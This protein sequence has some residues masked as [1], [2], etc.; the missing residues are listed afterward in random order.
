MSDDDE[1]V[2]AP[3]D[4]LLPPD[5][6]DADAPDG[7]DADPLD[8]ATAADDGEPRQGQGQ[9]QGQGREGEL[10][11]DGPLG[12]LAERARRGRDGSPDDDETMAAFETVEVDGV[13]V[14]QLWAELEHGDIDDTVDEPR[15]NTERDVEVV[16]KR[17]YCQRCQHF[18]APPEVR[19]THERGEILEMVDTEQFKVADCPILRGEEELE[20]LR[21]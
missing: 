2:D 12:D 14:D 6:G 3:G 21:R 13:D 15:S 10:D 16:A 4:D 7:G 18:S 19:C 20:N 8:P 17:D 11:P 9:G 1:A 5:G